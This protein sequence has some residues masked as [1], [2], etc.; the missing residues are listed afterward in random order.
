[1]AGNRAPD[2]TLQSACG[3][4]RR[5]FDLLRGPHWTAIGYGAEPAA[6]PA[7][8]PGLHVHHIGPEGAFRDPDRG[9]A[10]AYGLGDG[11][12]LLVR[13]DGYVGAFIAAGEHARVAAYLHACMA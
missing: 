2:A 4:E 6:L 11:D 3:Q 12:L 5:L 13:P 9:M 7:A 1:M 10:T 8:R